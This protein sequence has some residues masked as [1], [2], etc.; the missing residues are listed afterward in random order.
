[1]P[2]DRPPRT[3]GRGS[4]RMDFDRD[5]HPATGL[6]LL[7]TVPATCGGC[8]HLYARP[9]AHGDNLKCERK[10][11]K[12]R[13]G[14]NLQPLFPA[15]TAFE[16][17][18]PDEDEAQTLL[19]SGVEPW[20]LPVDATGRTVRVGH[21]AVQDFFERTGSG[22]VTK[23]FK[24]GGWF[25]EVVSENDGH[26]LTEHCNRLRLV[27]RAQIDALVRVE[28]EAHGH[29]GR[30]IEAIAGGR[31]GQFRTVCKCNGG[32]EL[33]E[34]GRSRAI[35]WRLSEAAARDLFTDHAA[36]APLQR[37]PALQV[38]LPLPRSSD[39]ATAVDPAAA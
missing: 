31:A 34:P 23:V 25:A 24:R 18:T 1:M 9:S 26:V 8:A 28:V 16:P 37:S 10:R 35:A 4:A 36:A 15:C 5:V 3:L 20:K 30:V 22:R 27:T 2:L 33:S 38:V 11:S 14:P 6:P 17:V 39:P 21:L 12:T 19:Q 32:F 13:K 7:T 29:R